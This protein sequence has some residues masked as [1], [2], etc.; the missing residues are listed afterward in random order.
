MSKS[1]LTTFLDKLSDVIREQD[2][3]SGKVTKGLGIIT[4]YKDGIIE[5][6]GLGNLKMGEIVEI[7][8]TNSKALIQNLERN[9]SFG[10][11][12][13]PD[14]SLK[15]GLYVKSTGK[16]LA[17]AVSDDLIG[18]VVDSLGEP[19]DGGKVIRAKAYY[20]HEKI[21]PGV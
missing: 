12:L 6:E 10:L 1:T 3:N 4:S 18:R 15:E 16:T 2:E 11:V 19:L 17:M 13:R 5:V 21:A 9:K 8:G 20:P 7:E 14:R